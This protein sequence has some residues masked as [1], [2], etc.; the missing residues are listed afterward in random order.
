MSPDSA[1]DV[2]PEYSYGKE[3]E[4]KTE[5]VIFD[6]KDDPF[7]SINDLTNMDPLSASYLVK[8]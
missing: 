4:S 1:E 7:G 2:F 8:R 6:G 5:S 3:E